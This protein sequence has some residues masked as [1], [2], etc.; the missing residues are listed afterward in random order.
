MLTTPEYLQV[1]KDT[2]SQK[3]GRWGGGP[4][5][6]MIDIMRFL[7]FYDVRSFQRRKPST[8]LDYGCGQGN[9]KITL[10]YDIKNYDVAIE[11]FS[12]D[13][14]VCDFLISTDVL[15]HVEE[16]CMDDVLSHMNSKFTRFAY[17][18]IVSNPARQILSDG[19][20][21]HITQKPFLWWLEKIMKHFELRRFMC[22]DARFFDEN[23][24]VYDFYVR[25]K[26]NRNFN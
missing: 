26:G 9:L 17:L 21:A 15:E 25:H 7:D 4:R 13:P 10:N 12:Q 1:L 11:K 6:K 16:E 18:S 5:K 23:Q 3:K 19:R 2:H 20:N 14:P 24:G 22:P 8:I